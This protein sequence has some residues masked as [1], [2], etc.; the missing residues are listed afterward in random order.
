MKKVE[1]TKI[2]NMRRK[3]KRISHIQNKKIS[4]EYTV[5]ERNVNLLNNLIELIDLNN[6]TQ[7]K[8]F[9]DTEMEDIAFSVNKNDLLKS[10]KINFKEFKENR[11]EMMYNYYCESLDRP[12]KFYNNSYNF[13]K[14]NFELDALN[15]IC[16]F[17]E[18]I[19]SII[20]KEKYLIKE[21]K[22][23][24]DEINESFSIL[25]LDNTEIPTQ[26]IIENKYNL[27][28]DNENINKTKLDFSY[29][30]LMERY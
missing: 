6:Y 25:K 27:L 28:K 17:I 16:K 21:I 1:I 4:K 15:I 2:G 20:E 13:F 8:I 18:E 23:T 19:I 24:Q 22:Y 9:L 7:F 10:S 29:K 14:D 3:K 12:I 5:Y 11:L 26:Y 30:L